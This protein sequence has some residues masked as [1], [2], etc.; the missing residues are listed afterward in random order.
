MKPVGTCLKP[1]EAG[2]SLQGVSDVL[3]VRY[4]SVV[5]QGLQWEAGEWKLFAG[6]KQERER[7]GGSGGMLCLSVKVSATVINLQASQSSPECQASTY[8][9]SS[10][11]M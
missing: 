7:G 6:H 1:G 8:S 4:C 5:G 3:L 10:R 2:E 9:E 11:S